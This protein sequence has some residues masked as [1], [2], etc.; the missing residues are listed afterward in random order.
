MEYVFTQQIVRGVV[1]TSIFSQEIIDKK[2]I[3]TGSR[4]EKNALIKTFLYPDSLTFYRSVFVF[5]TE[6]ELC[7]QPFK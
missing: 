6:L 3:P 1:K 5:E 7:I 4:Q 2:C